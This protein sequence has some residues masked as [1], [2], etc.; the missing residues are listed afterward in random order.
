MIRVLH[1]S[2]CGDAGGISSVIRNYYQFIDHEKVHFD[3]A[4]TVPTAGQN[5]HA[6]EAMGAKIFFIPLKSENMQGFRQELTRLL[7]EG[8][9]NALHVHE[10]ETSYVAL[11]IAKQ[12]GIPCRV[13][14]A[15]ITSP[16]EGI[17]GVL[18]RWSGCIFNYHYASHVIACGQLAGERIFGKHN[19]KRPKALVLPNAVDTEKFGF[20]PE[21]RREMRRELGVEDNYV[22]GMVARL[23]EQKNIPFAVEMMAKLVKKIPNAVLLIAGNGEDEQ[24]IREKIRACHMENTV[25]LLGRR[26]DVDRLYQAFDLFLLPSLYEGYPVAAVEAMSSGLPVLISTLVTDELK[27]GSAVQYL[28]LKN[29]ESWVE[30]AETWQQDGNRALRQKEIPEHNLDIRSCAEILLRV[31]EEDTALSGR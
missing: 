7:I 30:A 14:H 13:A 29:M 3:L 11:R 27:F 25:R 22:L 4:L 19:M 18:R 5:A 9:Y 21:I 17:R 6:L 1:I 20:R 23:S 31:Y 16:Y 8:K 2:G 24:L 26:A 15:H 12:L 10:S 28:S